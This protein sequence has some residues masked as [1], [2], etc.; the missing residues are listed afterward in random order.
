M[1]HA[2]EVVQGVQH[3]RLPHD[4]LHLK[5]AGAGGLVPPLGLVGRLHLGVVAGEVDRLGVG[6][7]ALE[8]SC[9]VPRGEGVLRLLEEDGESELGGVALGQRVGEEAAGQVQAKDKAR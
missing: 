7:A 6:R 5:E 4:D 3:V 1:A 2:G 8:A 9:R